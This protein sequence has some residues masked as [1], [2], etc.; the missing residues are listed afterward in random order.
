MAQMLIILR[1]DPQSGKQNI[2]VKLDSDPDALQS[3]RENLDLNPRARDSVTFV[4]A[5][6]ATAALPTADILTA[7]LTGALLTRSAAALGGAVR[8]G[9]VLI[10]SGLLAHERDEVCRAYGMPIV[11][12]RHED[13]WAGLAVK[14]S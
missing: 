9:G 7:N 11:W 14:K 10:L 6:L 5:D 4:E 8:A 1:R 3:A 12:E 2:V 13:G